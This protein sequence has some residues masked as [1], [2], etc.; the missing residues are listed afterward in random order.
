MVGRVVVRWSGV[1]GIEQAKILEEI[2]KHDAQVP[3]VGW[4]RPGS[5]EDDFGS[6][7]GVRL[8]GMIV[9]LIAPVS[10]ADVGDFGRRDYGVCGCAAKIAARLIDDSAV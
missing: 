6:G 3:D 2:P 1:D 9:A 8:D 10:E 7:E 5:S 4:I